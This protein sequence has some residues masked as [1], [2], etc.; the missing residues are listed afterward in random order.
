MNTPNEL[1]AYGMAE[2]I[3]LAGVNILIKNHS[4]RGILSDESRDANMDSRGFVVTNV[5]R[6]F[7][8]LRSEMLLAQGFLEK[9]VKVSYENKH[10]QIDTIGQDANTITITLKAV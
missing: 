2:V 10:Y 7:M 1:I 3:D 9:G 4:F 5:L 8:T 6:T